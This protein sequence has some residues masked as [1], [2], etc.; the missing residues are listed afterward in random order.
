MKSDGVMGC[1]IYYN[2][3]KF[4]NL[5]IESSTFTNAQGE[6]M[7]QI[8]VIGSFKHKENGNIIKIVTTHLKAKRGFEDVRES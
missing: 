4:E 6:D 2:A 5:E 1:S 8:Y 3:Q 7:N